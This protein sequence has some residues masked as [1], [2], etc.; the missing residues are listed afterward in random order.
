[1]SVS[2]CVISRFMWHLRWSNSPSRNLLF[3][4]TLFQLDPFRVWSLCWCAWWFSALRF[5]SRWLNVA[6]CVF[7]LAWCGNYVC[8]WGCLKGFSTVA[9]VTLQSPL[10]TLRAVHLT[11]IVSLVSII[12][13]HTDT[14]AFHIPIVFT[15]SQ[16][17]VVVLWYH[18]M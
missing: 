5:G 13:R 16:Q 15:E 7:W 8:V 17:R 3:S 2:V 9:R 10:H 12:R 6:Q 18:I 1:M 11:G 14:P 4:S